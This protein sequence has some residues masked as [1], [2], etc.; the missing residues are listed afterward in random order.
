[1]CT[2]GPVRE[3]DVVAGV[4]LDGLSRIDPF[5]PDDDPL[6]EAWEASSRGDTSDIMFSVPLAN[7]SGMC[8][9]GTTTRQALRL[10]SLQ[11]QNCYVEC[12]WHEVALICPLASLCEVLDGL[13]EVFRLTPMQTNR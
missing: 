9:N 13:L 4:M 2:C 5:Y 8:I 11:C 3:E 10:H 7:F 12:R 6:Q 1:M